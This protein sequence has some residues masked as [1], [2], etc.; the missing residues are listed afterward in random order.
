MSWL[1]YYIYLVLCKNTI[2]NKIFNHA[3]VN[4]RC[5]QKKNKPNI[6]GTADIYYVTIIYG[7]EYGY[8]C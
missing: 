1:L 7:W 4:Q 5:T 8:K 6:N 3:E 2:K